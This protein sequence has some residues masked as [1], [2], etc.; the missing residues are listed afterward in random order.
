VDCHS[1][2]CIGSC[3][4]NF[5]KMGYI[6]HDRSIVRV[7][8]AAIPSVREIILQ[9]LISDPSL[10]ALNTLLGGCPYWSVNVIR[11]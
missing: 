1:W 2:S 9:F 10:S 8:K 3:L 11:K 6:E 4:R 7:S 5:S